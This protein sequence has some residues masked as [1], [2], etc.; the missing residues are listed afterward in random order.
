MRDTNMTVYRAILDA[1]RDRLG[2][3]ALLA[4]GK[5]VSYA[6]LFE[7]A[8][9]VADILATA[10]VKAGDLILAQ[11][12]GTPES[13]ALLLAASKSGVSVMMLNQR[14]SEQ[15]LA[16]LVE[17]FD[18]RFLF[19]MEKFFLTIADYSF[20][21]DDKMVVVLP[22]DA[23]RANPARSASGTCSNIMKWSAF[24]RLPADF[25]ATE[26][27]HGRYPM[28]ICSTSGSSGVPKGIVQTNQSC[29]ELMRIFGPA[30]S[31]WTEKDLYACVFPFF[32]TSGQSFNLFLPLAAGMT[33]LIDPDVSLEAFWDDIETH[34]PTIA[35]LVKYNWLSLIRIA[36]ER[37]ARPD[38]SRLRMAYAVGAKMTDAERES[39]DSFL[40]ECGAACRITNLFGL[41][42]TNSILACESKGDAGWYF[43]PLDAVRIICRSEE[44]G[45]ALGPGLRG[46]LL[47]RTPCLMQGYLMDPR[48]TE[49]AFV[50]DADGEVWFDTADIGYLTEDGGFVV[51]GRQTD[52]FRFGGKSVYVFEIKKLLEASPLVRTC[53]VYFNRSKDELRAYV[54]PEDDSLAS[55]G[56]GDEERRNRQE[57]TVRRLADHL[58]SSGKIGLFPSKFRFLEAIPLARSGKPDIMALLD[59]EDYIA[60]ER[61]KGENNR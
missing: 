43:R 25:R 45:E 27:T 61:E 48:M 24:M 41:S 47:F 46:R 51:E 42:E 16:S 40:S 17:H 3:P 50:K 57:E 12:H 20:I 26:V 37:G 4:G 10:G 5:K 34:S 13:A 30:V 44:T 9:R 35:L 1:N 11:I 36:E 38:L 52:L 7:M 49:K 55:R 21:D 14:T 58:V 15:T 22:K 60:S 32:L 59:L 23:D 19:V 33:V 31:G 53:E 8:D 18:V 2:T 54:V 56:D 39:V 28:S 6:E 29:V